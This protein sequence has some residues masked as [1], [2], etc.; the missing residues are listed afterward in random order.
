VT[1]RWAVVDT[2]L[3]RSDAR[4]GVPILRLEWD[5]VHEQN[6]SNRLA[7]VPS[8]AAV[9]MMLRTAGFKEVYWIQNASRDLPLDYR[10]EARM[11][12]VA[13]K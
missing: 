13:A 2:T 9:P 3:A 5:D 1:R 8:K 12:F 6:I 11:T 4:D 7:L 10:T